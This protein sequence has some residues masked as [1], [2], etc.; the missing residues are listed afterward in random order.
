MPRSTSALIALL[1]A[2]A[3]EDDLGGVMCS[4]TF[5]YFLGGWMRYTP[6]LMPFYAPNV[7]SYKVAPTPN[8][9][10][11]PTFFV[12]LSSD[13]KHNLGLRRSWRGVQITAP[14]GIIRIVRC[15]PRLAHSSPAF[16]VTCRFRVVGHGPSLRI[17]CRLPG[18]DANPYLAFSAALAAG[19]RGI[20]DKVSIL[21]SV[22]LA[23]SYACT[24]V[25]T[26][27]SRVW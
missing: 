2:F 18:G 27:G 9:A 26:T 16:A 10:T 23:C 25:G 19:L 12:C 8:C 4:E 14:S 13:S 11:F 6:E 20:Q 22:S 21:T 24:A 7:N 17:E 1:V 15:V 3:G 5:K